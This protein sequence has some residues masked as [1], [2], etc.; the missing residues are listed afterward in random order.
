MKVA[1]ATAWVSW[2]MSSTPTRKPNDAASC[3]PAPLN[4]GSQ[5][6]WRRPSH[7]NAE[8]S[9]ANTLAVARADSASGTANVAN[10]T[11]STAYA[12]PSTA[13]LA[14]RISAAA[15]RA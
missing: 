12:C 6:R 8:P 10:P 3:R 15:S 7:A 11:A 1:L 14:R 4:C 5:R 2:A 9:N 13:K